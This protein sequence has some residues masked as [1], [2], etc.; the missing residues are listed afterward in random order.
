MKINSSYRLS[1]FARDTK[2]EIPPWTNPKRHPSLTKAAFVTV[3]RRRALLKELVQHC[4]SFQLVVSSDNMHVIANSKKGWAEIIKAGWTKKDATHIWKNDGSWPLKYIDT[5]KLILRAED[6]DHIDDV[7]KSKLELK[8]LGKRLFG[9]S[10]SYWSK[11]GGYA[12][13]RTI[14]SAIKKLEA[15]GFKPRSNDSGGSPDGSYMG[16]TKVYQKGSILV[17][18]R[19]MYGS[20]ASQNSFSIEIGREE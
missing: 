7:G 19:S 4:P 5:G 1:I 8:A 11:Y 18:I 12:G 17:K 16:N 10:A 13:E 2:A 14:R 20:T 6:V 15:L 9:Q 3:S